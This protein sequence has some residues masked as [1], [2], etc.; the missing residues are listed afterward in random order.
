MK[1]KSPF[2]NINHDTPTI[3]KEALKLKTIVL[4]EYKDVNTFSATEFVDLFI[5]IFY[6]YI[7]TYKY[8][9]RSHNINKERYIASCVHK[10]VVVYG[11]KLQQLPFVRKKAGF[12]ENKN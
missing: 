7:H 6:T 5:H 3:L 9:Y 4:R 1:A 8:G 11:I 12:L 2:K 10:Y